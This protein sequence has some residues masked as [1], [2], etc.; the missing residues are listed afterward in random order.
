MNQLS[1]A[2]TQA[3]ALLLEASLNPSLET[4]LS[5]AFGDNY[6]VAIANNIFSSWRNGDFSNLP[7]IEI[8]SP[9][10]INGAQ[11]AY[12]ALNN[13]IYLSSSLVESEFPKKI[14]NVLLEE[15]GHFIDAQINLVDTP[16]DE[17]AIFSLL[18]RGEDISPELLTTLQNK[19]DSGFVSVDGQLIDVENATFNLNVTTTFDQ[20]DGT[21]ENGLSLR[22]AVIF[23][24]NNP[25][26][27]YVIVLQPGQT[28]TLTQNGSHEDSALTGDL[29]IRGNIT[30]RTQGTGQTPATIDARG[31]SQRDRVFDVLNDATLTL[32]NVTVTGGYAESSGGGV[33]VNNNGTLNVFSSTIDGNTATFDGGGV[34]ALSTVNI[35][36]STISNNRVIA[37]SFGE[38]GGGLRLNGN[39]LIENST[40][41]GNTSNRDAG[42][43]YISS[44]ETIITNSTIT[45]NVADANSSG[46]GNGGG[47]FRS[48]VN[49]SLRNTIVAGNRDLSPSNLDIHPDVSGNI[50][51][52][53]N[54]L[55]G[56][57]RGAS[58]TIGTGT[59]IV[60]NNIRLAPLGNYGGLTKTHALYQGSP[61][62][63]AGNNSLIPPDT[64]DLNNNG[65]TD[66]FATF[67]QR[68]A[69]FSRIIDGTVDI[70]AFE[71]VLPPPTFNVPIYRFQ[72]RS[73]PGTYLFVGEEERRSVKANY[74]NFVEEGF[75]FNVANSGGDG[76]IA[77]N[78]FQNSSVPGTYLF[79]GEAESIVIRQNFRNFVEEGV[80]F[81]VHAPGS[82]QGTTY[83]RFQNLNLPGTYLFAGPEETASITQNFPSFVNEGIAFGAG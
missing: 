39:V 12:S 18:A 33:R 60:N 6:N 62:I 45:N 73:V 3:E 15:Y 4:N 23:A 70:G 57:L 34:F 14:R 40:I 69:S 8:L 5:I 43:L 79:A 20:N 74:P 28:Y 67:D 26:V 66:E 25:A 56:D 81:Y 75:A 78:R 10:E 46:S 21:A 80:A 82:G 27:E 61:A 64:L 51:G 7:T 24:N 72:N 50:N 9:T 22:D 32:E 49:I 52:D 2:L 35:I 65:I 55:I 42:G 29:D 37:N 59:D 63:N 11:G 58:G 16:G 77:L 54:N 19:D 38:G 36:N 41:S 13:T 17:G 53:N 31:L 1:Q 48:G 44:T 30:V 71:G 47:I 68:G 83:N 76:L